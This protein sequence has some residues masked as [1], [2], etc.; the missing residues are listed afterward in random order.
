MGARACDYACQNNRDVLPRK[1]A[2]SNR[3]TKLSSITRP[4]TPHQEAHL[5]KRN[6]PNEIIHNN[7]DV[8]AIPRPDHNEPVTSPCQRHPYQR[9][10]MIGS[11]SYRRSTDLAPV[12]AGFAE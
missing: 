12:P 11:E 8:S 10:V 4:V 5:V 6:V 9:V 2:V 7:K 1:L 3:L